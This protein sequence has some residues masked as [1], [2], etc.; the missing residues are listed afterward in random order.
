MDNISIFPDDMDLTTTIYIP[1]VYVLNME[2]IKQ[3]DNPLDIMLELLNI[4][5]G[6]CHREQIDDSMFKYFKKLEED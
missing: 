6:A 1:P 5:F 4:E 3:S 2:E